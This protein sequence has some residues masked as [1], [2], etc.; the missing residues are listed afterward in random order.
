MSRA[1]GSAP[2]TLTERVPE[3]IALSSRAISE[4]VVSCARARFS[5]AS[6]QARSVRIVSVVQLMYA[7]VIHHLRK[8][9]TNR[10]LTP[11]RESSVAPRGR[12]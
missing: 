3:R 5:R 10:R 2:G 8:Q 9:R 1:H 11:F 12:W 6:R 4:T 7:Q